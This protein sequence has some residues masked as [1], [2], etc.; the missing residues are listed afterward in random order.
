MSLSPLVPFSRI[1]P[2][3]T[4]CLSS[5]DERVRDVAPSRGPRYLYRIPRTVFR[6]P[7]TPDRN[8]N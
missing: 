5:D 2:V 7:R 4:P 1:S 6:E 3:F 8:Q